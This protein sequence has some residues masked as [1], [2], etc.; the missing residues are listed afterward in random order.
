[1]VANQTESKLIKKTGG[2]AGIVAGQTTISAAGGE[3]TLEYRGYSIYDLAKNSEFEEVAYLLVYGKLPNLSELK[4]Y[5]E[6]IKNL[7]DLPQSLKIFLEMIPSSS[8][9]MDVM[10]SATSFLGNIEMEDA[11]HDQY[12][13]TDRLIAIY[14][15][16]IAYW[17]HYSRSG[18]K[19]DCRT[20]EPNIAAHFLR[21]LHQ[22]EPDALHVEAMNV[23][24]ILYAE[25][26]FNASTFTARTITSTRSDFY[27]AVCGAIGALRGNLHGG[28]NEAAM[29]LIEKFNT[30]ED[31]ISGVKKMMA[32]KE[33]IMGFGHRVYSV[34][35]PRNRVIK[36]WSRKLCS[37]V[38]KDNLFDVS[39]AIENLMWSEKALFPNLDFYSASAYN[40]MN[41]PTPLFTPIFVMSRITGWAAH[42]IEQRQ[43][44]KLIRPSADYTGP[45]GLQLI[46]I[47]ERA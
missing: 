31:A 45:N 36:E 1:M 26:E 2:L 42:I 11:L 4:S 7:R 28:A 16:V 44:N 15:A 35:D 13:V 47:S 21:L 20:N 5:K 8:H 12:A 17:W 30:S 18:I 6:R 14:P 33:L 37:Q 34:A 10:R 24:L 19:I 32:D 27:S 40:A 3:H 43:N 46:S 38:N 25:H 41:I 23:S 39:E 22:N 9:P 29:D